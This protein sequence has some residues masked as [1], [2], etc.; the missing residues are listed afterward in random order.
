VARAFA[1]SGPKLTHDVD[2]DR[3]LRACP[4]SATTQGTYFRYLRDSIEAA[5]GANPRL[6]EG[7]ET[8]EWVAFRKY[9]M[10]D[11]MLLSI[12]AARI[13]YAGEALSE[14]LRRLGWLAFQSFSA[15]MAGRVV[16]FAF[17]ERLENVIWALPKAYAVSVPGAVIETE[18]LGPRRYRI[19]MK[20][21]YNF[22]DTYHLGVLEGAVLAMG[23]QPAINVTVG[24]K[25][26]DAVFEGGW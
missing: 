22:V 7:L 2:V 13:A 14:G 5:F 12:N 9:P 17:G 18:E 1:F 6:V 26:C 23:F 11:F 8:T 25:L 15:T 19:T 24:E 3:Y 4:P 20:N 16:L 21:L 10:R